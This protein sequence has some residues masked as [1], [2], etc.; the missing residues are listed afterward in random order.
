V[1]WDD[2]DQLDDED[3]A[4]DDSDEFDGGDDDEDEPTIE[5]PY[6]GRE[7]HED[8]QRCPH[9]EQYISRENAPPQRK[10]WWVVAGAMICLYIAWR[11]IMG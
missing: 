5:C 11:W 7:I 8:A 2:D 1:P 6:C 9:C 4:G 3:E 10:P